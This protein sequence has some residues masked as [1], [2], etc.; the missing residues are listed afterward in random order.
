MSLEI[1]YVQCSF[2]SNLFGQYEVSVWFEIVRTVAV[3]LYCWC[4]RASGADSDESGK[5]YEELSSD[6]ANRY[7]I[8]F[9]VRS[10]G[11]VPI[12]DDQLT[13]ENSSRA[14]NQCIVNLS[15]GMRDINDVVG[16]W[17]DVSMSQCIIVSVQCARAHLM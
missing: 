13:Q 4:Y 9:A 15:S 8:R 3:R 6:V 17:G 2:R 5:D 14:V 16:R 10:L 1:V 11:W 7:P 12:Q